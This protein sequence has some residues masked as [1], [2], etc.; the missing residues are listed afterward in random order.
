MLRFKIHFDHNMNQEER[1]ISLRKKKSKRVRPKEKKNQMIRKCE[2]VK[3]SM[4]IKRY[5]NYTYI[6][7][8]EP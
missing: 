8:S 5:C 7:R 6:Q 3:M 4:N 2:N 1:F